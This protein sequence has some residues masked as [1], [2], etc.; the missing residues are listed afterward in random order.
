MLDDS[1]KEKLFVLLIMI[2]LAVSFILHIPHYIEV[3]NETKI[4][5]TK[6]DVEMDNT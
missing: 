6:T 4:K 5:S 2:V 1:T 3:W